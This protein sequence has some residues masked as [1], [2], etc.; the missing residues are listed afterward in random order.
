MARVMP[1]NPDRSQGLRRAM[2]RSVELKAYIRISDEG[3][4]IEFSDG[5]KTSLPREARVSSNSLT[6]AAVQWARRH[7]ATSIEVQL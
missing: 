1:I 6:A 2:W 7:G 3:V 4:D 5:R